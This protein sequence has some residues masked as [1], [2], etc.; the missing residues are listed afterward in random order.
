[1]I[2]PILCQI[3]N[4]DGSKLS[5]AQYMDG[6]DIKQNSYFCSLQPHL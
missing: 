5:T 6:L 4:G 3:V 2:R 1:M